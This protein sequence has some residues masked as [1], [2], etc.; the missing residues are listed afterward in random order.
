MRMT[1]QT[2]LELRFY[3]ILRKIAKEYMTPNQ[4]RRN[5]E[6]CWGC[7]YEEILEMTYENIQMEAA[8]AIKGFRLPKKKEDNAEL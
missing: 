4:L 3:V 2:D 7:E 8:A 6:P 1:I 5:A